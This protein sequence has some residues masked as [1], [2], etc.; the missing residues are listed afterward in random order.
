[1]NMQ[2]DN[3]P[4]LAQLIDHS[5]PP[6]PGRDDFKTALRRLNIHSILDIVRLSEEA[7]TEQLKSTTM[8]MPTRCISRPRTLP[9]NWKPYFANSKSRRPLLHRAINAVSPKTSAIYQALFQE[10]WDQF[11]SS[12]SIAA[13]DSPIAYLRA[14]YLFALQLEE[15][16][17]DTRA[18]KLSQRRPE[19][20]DLV[21]NQHS[22]SGQVPMLSIVNQ[23]LLKN[24][25]QAKKKIPIRC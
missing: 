22:V 14:L 18:L 9:R 2:T 11:C 13:V 6:A 12:S 23:I 24:I 4:L 10:K 15:N 19:L 17:K 1:M 3:S 5:R 7:F 21:L 16:T 20:K 25:A 8:T